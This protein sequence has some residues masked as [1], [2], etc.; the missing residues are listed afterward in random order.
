MIE[1]AAGTDPHLLYAAELDH[2]AQIAD[3]A[4]QHALV[5]YDDEQRRDPAFAAILL[6]AARS[7]RAAGRLPSDAIVEA[8]E[9]CLAAQRQAAEG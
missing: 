6:N 4:A 8:M 3:G 9:R 2:L 1:D 5:H 7:L